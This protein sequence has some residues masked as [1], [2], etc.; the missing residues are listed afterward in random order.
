MCN[1][2]IRAAWGT[3]EELTTALLGC[4]MDRARSPYR[5]AIKSRVWPLGSPEDALIVSRVGG[6]HSASNMLSERF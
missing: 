5:A 6:D 4:Y 1:T 3:K 2:A